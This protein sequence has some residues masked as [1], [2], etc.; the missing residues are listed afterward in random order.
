MLQEIGAPDVI[1]SISGYNPLTGQ[2]ENTYWEFS[3]PGGMNFPILSGQGY[4]VFMKIEKTWLPG[5]SP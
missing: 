1:L 3:K 4:L 5:F 2:W